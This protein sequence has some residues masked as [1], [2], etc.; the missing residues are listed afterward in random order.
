MI[1]FSLAAISQSDAITIEG[2][3]FFFSTVA[4]LGM[5]I[6]LIF[7]ASSAPS[8]RVYPRKYE[9][10][11]WS[12]RQKLFK[13]LGIAYTPCAVFSESCQILRHLTKYDLNDYSEGIYYYEKL[14]RQYG[15]YLSFHY[16]AP[17]YIK[18][19]S[20]VVGYGLFADQDI[21]KGA[22][23]MEYGGEVLKR[24]TNAT[25]S[26]SY[27]S[28]SGFWDSQMSFSLAANEYGNEARF[29]NHG[30]NPNMRIELIY[31]DGTWRLAYIAD[32][33]IKKGDEL[34]INYGPGY[35]KNRWKISLQNDHK[36]T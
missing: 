3:H 14:N 31:S 19:V 36:I 1:N 5:A 16:M 2:I 26:W 20:N 30:D 27:P 34:F 28:R 24:S 25:W 32:R 4:M 15:A 18:W 35:W 12:D 22:F 21:R 10:R 6:Y 29:A 33:E 23:I 13:K 9:I 8:S 7:N 11:S 17:V